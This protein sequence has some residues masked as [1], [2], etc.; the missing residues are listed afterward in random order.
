MNAVAVRLRHGYSSYLSLSMRGRTVDLKTREPIFNVPA[1]VGAV[2]AIMVAVHVGRSFLTEQQD[3]WLVA[4]LAFI[5]ARYDGY[6][7]DLPGGVTACFTSFITHMFVHGDVTHLTFNS[8]WLLAFGSA[9][10][11]RLGGLRFLAVSAFTGIAGAVAFL[12]FHPGLPAPVIGA[13]GAVAGL[14]G[15]TMRFLFSALDDGGFWRLREEPR[16]IP[17][18]PLSV[19]L[20]DRRILT[21]TGI[22]LVLNFLA[23]FGFGGVSSEGGIAW[24]AH[25]GGFAAGLFG[26]GL[27]DTI[28]RPFSPKP[29]TT[30]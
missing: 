12:L 16:T 29:G 13:S 30:Q 2:L 7:A 6:A 17:A 22:W 14:M 21:A 10:A 25:L 15:A 5:P 26:F 18:M 19:A 11:L 27:F 3:N 20:R 28:E 23:L 24:E 1:S 8:A 9:V 4:L